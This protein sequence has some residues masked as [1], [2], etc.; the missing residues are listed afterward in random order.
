MHSES[1]SSR[2]SSENKTSGRLTSLDQFRGYTVFGMLVV[3]YFGG[4]VACPQVWKH[5][6]DYLSYADTIMP[7]FL[8]AVGFSLR[9]TVGRQL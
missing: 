2:L 7:Q 3:N 5:T 4:Y 1:S 9:L 6:H 8:F